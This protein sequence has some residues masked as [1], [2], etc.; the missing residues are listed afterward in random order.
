MFHGTHRSFLS[1]RRACFFD[2]TTLYLKC[3][4]SSPACF[5]FMQICLP[6]GSHHKKNGKILEKFP[7]GGGNFFLK[8]VPISELKVALR[9]QE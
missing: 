8:N 4:T 3:G 9:H 5:F 1:R 6:K 2:K 7:K